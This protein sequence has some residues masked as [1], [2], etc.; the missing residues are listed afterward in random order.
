VLIVCIVLSSTNLHSGFP[1]VHKCPHPHT[2]THT[3]THT[4]THTH[5]HTHTHTPEVNA[6][7]VA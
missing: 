7:N 2:H 5:T 4:D 3:H 6:R 1:P